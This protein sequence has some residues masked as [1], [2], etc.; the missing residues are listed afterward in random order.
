M[1]MVKMTMTMLLWN[2]KKYENIKKETVFS[3]EKAI[4]L[5]K[6]FLDALLQTWLLIRELTFPVGMGK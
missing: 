1:A 3:V 6:A 5:D 2:A 4:F